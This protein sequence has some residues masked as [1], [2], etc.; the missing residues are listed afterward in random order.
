[1]IPTFHFSGWRHRGSFVSD[2]DTEPPAQHTRG[3]TCEPIDEATGRHRRQ[4][5]GV[6][7]RQTHSHARLNIA[8]P[9]PLLTTSVINGLRYTLAL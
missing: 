4:S 6:K 9:L 7:A 8:F 2:L 5:D 1:M 3:P